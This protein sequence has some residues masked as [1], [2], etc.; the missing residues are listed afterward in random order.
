VPVEAPAA[1][2]PDPLVVEAEG[3]K[4][5]KDVVKMLLDHDRT[6]G[7]PELLTWARA[8]RDEVAILRRIP[9][10]LVEDRVKTTA[11]FYLPAA[12]GA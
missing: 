10:H 2:V 3:A 4:F 9:E 1:G 12:P 5:L 11:G 7:L 8:H 6:W